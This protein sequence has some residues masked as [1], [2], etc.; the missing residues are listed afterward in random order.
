MPSHV[1]TPTPSVPHTS[2]TPPGY[3]PWAYPPGA[4]LAPGKGS[5]QCGARGTPSHGALAARPQWAERQSGAAAVAPQGAV[6]W[7][8][9]A[10]Q[11]AGCALLVRPR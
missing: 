9:V 3:A 1:D 8:A 4:T 10:R 7:H 6:A 5:R 2:G 11:T